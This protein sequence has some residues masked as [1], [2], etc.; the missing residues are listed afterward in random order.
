MAGMRDRLIHG[1]DIVYPELI[2]ITVKKTIPEIIPKI[3]VHIE[4]SLSV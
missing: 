3:K 1:Y 2:W 4:P